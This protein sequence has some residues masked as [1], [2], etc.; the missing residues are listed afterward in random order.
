MTLKNIEIESYKGIS[1][2][3]FSPKKINL[4]VGKNNTGKTSIL[5]AIDLLFHNGHIQ[6]RN[7]HSYLN[8]YSKNK[9][10]KISADIGEEKEKIEIKEAK[11]LEVVN[12]FIKDLIKNFLDHLTKKSKKSFNEILIKE[13]EKIAEKHID[14]ELRKILL[15]NALVLINNKN[16][17]K[18]YYRFDEYSV[19]DKIENLMENISDYILNKLIPEEQK[20]EYFKYLRYASE[21]TIFS[22]RGFLN[23]GKISSK[24]KNCIFIKSLRDNTMR[25]SFLQRKPKD[26]ERLHKVEEIV[27]KNNLIGNLEE[28]NF[29]NVLFRTE[30]GEIKA[31]SF[32]FLGDGFKS[33]IGLLWQFSSDKME[34]TIILFDEPETHMHPGYIKELIKFIIYFSKKLN[35]QFFITTHNSD[36]LDIFLRG[37]MGEDEKDY[38]KKEL[39]V[40]KMNKIKDYITLAEELNYDDARET[41]EELFLDLRG[42]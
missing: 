34:D 24:K 9:N 14:E 28:L 15:R 2:L 1:K 16:E 27:K 35:I 22:T 8:I 18:I 39:S 26:S 36:V 19:I 20:A 7:M 21:Y 17:E 23:G 41:E 6:T 30:D 32:N 3:K 10:I 4:I 37:N 40:L 25:E 5:E 42:I 33:L 38:I 13:L 31:H 11:E 29:D 12:A